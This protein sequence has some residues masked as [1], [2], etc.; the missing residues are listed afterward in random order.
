MVDFHLVFDGLPLITPITILAGGIAVYYSAYGISKILDSLNNRPIREKQ[1]EVKEVKKP[2]KFKGA[3][4]GGKVPRENEARKPV[5]S[6]DK[7]DKVPAV[8]KDGLVDEK[9]RKR[10]GIF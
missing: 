9:Y 3:D 5:K 8:I 6:K 4:L 1:V 7:F 2:F 10:F